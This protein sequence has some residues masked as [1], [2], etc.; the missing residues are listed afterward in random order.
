MKIKTVIKQTEKEINSGEAHRF[1]VLQFFGNLPRK[2]YDRAI[3]AYT[4]RIDFLK[5]LIEAEGVSEEHFYYK[6]KANLVSNA[7]DLIEKMEQERKASRGEVE[8]GETEEGER[9]EGEHSAE[10]WFFGQKRFAE[11]D[12]AY[13]AQEVIEVETY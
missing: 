9:E 12:L 5:G 7:K 13:R 8:E 2:D 3:E 11:M 4:A 10:K 1:S 6:I